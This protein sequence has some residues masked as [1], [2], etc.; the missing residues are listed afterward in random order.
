M[1]SNDE[2]IHV[3]VEEETNAYTDEVAFHHTPVF[4]N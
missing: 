4:F 3:L 1:D 2:V